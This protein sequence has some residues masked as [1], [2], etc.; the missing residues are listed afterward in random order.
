MPKPAT[1]EHLKHGGL[2]P[3]IADLYQSLQGPR[4]RQIGVAAA[5]IEG[6]F[7]PVHVFAPAKHSEDS[8]AYRIARP[9][10]HS[11]HLGGG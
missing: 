11:R 2:F 4:P 5:R 10:L 8:G 6:Q 7:Y 3:N 1:R 9:A